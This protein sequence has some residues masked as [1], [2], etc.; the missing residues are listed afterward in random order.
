MVHDVAKFGPFA[1]PSRSRCDRR[2]QAR[3]VVGARRREAG[4]ADAGEMLRR[5]A[6]VVAEHP[7]ESFATAHTPERPG[8]AGHRRDDRVAESLVIPLRVVVHEVLSE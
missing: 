5:I 4:P 2:E 7:T 8:W 1:G 6:M 3:L